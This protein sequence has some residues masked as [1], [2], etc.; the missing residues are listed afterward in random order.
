MENVAAVEKVLSLDIHAFEMPEETKMNRIAMALSVEDRDTCMEA[1][2]YG[3]YGVSSS[4][5]GIMF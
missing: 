4:S 5:Y 3:I 1:S 2:E